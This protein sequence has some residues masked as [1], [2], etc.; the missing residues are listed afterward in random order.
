MNYCLNGTELEAILLL[1]LENKTIEDV[2]LKSLIGNAVQWQ[3][4]L[5]CMTFSFA[6]ILERQRGADSLNEMMISKLFSLPNEMLMDIQEYD[7]DFVNYMLKSEYVNE[8]N[9][10]SALITVTRRLSEHDY[11]KN[12]LRN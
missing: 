8:S 7:E 5:I 3:D 12:T 1:F 10:E 11:G 6:R 2:T 4:N 9:L